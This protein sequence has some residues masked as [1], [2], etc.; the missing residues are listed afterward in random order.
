MQRGNRPWAGTTRDSGR[1]LRVGPAR[2]S[3]HRVMPGPKARPGR[4]A[5]AIPARW[6]SGRA[7][8]GPGR[9]GPAR[10]P[11]IVGRG[12]KGG[13]A[14]GYTECGLDFRCLFI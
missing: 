12:S 13:T 2:K 10:W 3:A 4:H 9:A 1:A 14:E 8:T 11:S 6:L 5:R 7:G